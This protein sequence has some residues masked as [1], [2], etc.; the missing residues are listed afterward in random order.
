M[1]L[2]NVSPGS[3]VFIGLKVVDDEEY[4]SELSNVVSVYF[5]EPREE[6]EGD[7]DGDEMKTQGTVLLSS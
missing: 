7:D 4:Y 2:T 1:L 5:V 3:T 6:E